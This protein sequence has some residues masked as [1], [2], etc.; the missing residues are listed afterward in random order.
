MHNKLTDVV[1]TDIS[2][3]R[4]PPVRPD[5]RLLEAGAPDVMHL[6]QL[7]LSCHIVYR[8]LAVFESATLII[9]CAQSVVGSKL[10]NKTL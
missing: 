8:G 10:M 2:L 1:V 5:E 3:L 9:H 7:T 4:L 6:T